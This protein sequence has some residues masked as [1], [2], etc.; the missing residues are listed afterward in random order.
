MIKT[1]EEDLIGWKTI[2]EIQHKDKNV[3][4]IKC[5][6]IELF[7]PKG[8]R[9]N[10]DYGLFFNKCRCEKAKVLKISNINSDKKF[11]LRNTHHFEHILSDGMIIED[12][13]QKSIIHH[14]KF[15]ECQ[16]KTI[17]RIGRYVYPDKFDD[18]SDRACS[19]GIHFFNSRSDALQWALYNI[20]V[21]LSDS[22]T[23][24]YTLYFE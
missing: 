13:M 21:E 24:V 3:L 10:I 8:T 7:I 17:Y 4:Y 14:T 5:R 18:I 16:Q 20:F 22:D 23:T 1:L 2:T 15:N 6:L 12:S 19:N 9:C 11:E